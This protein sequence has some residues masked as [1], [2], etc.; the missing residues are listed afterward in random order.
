MEEL[1]GLAE[2]LRP[3]D[4]LDY[5]PALPRARSQSSCGFIPGSEDLRRRASR[6]RPLGKAG[7][8]HHSLM[9]AG[10]RGRFIS[11]H[12]GAELPGADR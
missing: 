11:S 12:R 3:S 2:L 5:L 6:D 8:R 9:P 1:A 7:A 4:C 10:L